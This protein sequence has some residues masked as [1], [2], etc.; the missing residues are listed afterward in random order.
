MSQIGSLIR[1]P[2]CR[3]VTPCRVHDS[4]PV[5]TRNETRRRR[6][7][8]V[9]EQTFTTYERSTKRR[10]EPT[11]PPLDAQAR[12]AHVLAENERLTRTLETLRRRRR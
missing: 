11:A 9:C 10:A 2:F 12:L 3:V 8:V 1:C 5:P 4:R 7:C 6:R